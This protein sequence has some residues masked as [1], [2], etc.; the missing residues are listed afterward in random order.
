MA[1]IAAERRVKRHEPHDW[2]SGE[3]PEEVEEEQAVLVVRNHEDGT[4]DR[5]AA[6]L[7]S[8]YGNVGVGVDSSIERR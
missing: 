6:G 5:L 2:N 3:N 7:R 1:G 8:A 4:R